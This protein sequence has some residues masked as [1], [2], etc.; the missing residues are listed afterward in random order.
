[1]HPERVG[2]GVEHAVG[3]RVERLLGILVVDADAGI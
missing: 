3:Q 1:M 2:T